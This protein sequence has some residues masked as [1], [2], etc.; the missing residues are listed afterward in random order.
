MRSLA[1]TDPALP[2]CLIA[3]FR[4]TAIPPSVIPLAKT[5]RLRSLTGFS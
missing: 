2:L 1:L 4:P 5:L 3:E